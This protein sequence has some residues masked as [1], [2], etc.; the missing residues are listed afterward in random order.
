MMA[1]IAGTIALLIL[2]IGIAVNDL[3]PI[4]IG[5]AIFILAVG[6]MKE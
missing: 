3:L 1:V 4:L 5:I 2:L 6:Q